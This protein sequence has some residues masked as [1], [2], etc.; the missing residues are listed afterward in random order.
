ELEAVIDEAHRNG[1]PITAHATLDAA[2]RRVLQFGIDCVEHGGAMSDETIGLLVKRGVP[3]VTTFSPMVLQSDP[4][5]ARRHGLP[6]WKIK[7]RQ[8]AMA[9]PNRFA[10]LVRAAQAGVP[11]AFGMD[12]GSPAVTHGKVAPEMQFMVKLGLV[13]GPYGA[14]HSATDTSAR[15][16][17]LESSLGTLEAGKLADVVVVSGNPLDDLQALSQVQMTFQS[18][19]RVV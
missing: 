10:D 6:E 11:I 14:I 15:L 4:E 12:A 18:G 9:D 17:R 13:D 1:L 3:I 8:Q 16:N 19:R 5:I 7:E 2:V